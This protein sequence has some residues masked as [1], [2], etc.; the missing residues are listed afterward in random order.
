MIAIGPGTHFEYKGNYYISIAEYDLEFSLVSSTPLVLFI[1][2]VGEFQCMY[3]ACL[4]L[5]YILEKYI[6]PKHQEEVITMA[7]F[8]LACRLWDGTMV[9]AANR[10][11]MPWDWTTSGK[12][13][14]FWTELSLFFQMH[15]LK[16]NL[17]L[18]PNYSL[19]PDLS[20]LM[21]RCNMWVF[22]CCCS[23]WWITFTSQKKHLN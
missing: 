22:I 14:W 15:A 21:Q 18:S 2:T 5:K 3:Q 1:V 8:L 10:D 13:N 12:S 20:A 16:G 17:T 19:Q 9:A 11:H 23:Q 7:I 6:L 4:V